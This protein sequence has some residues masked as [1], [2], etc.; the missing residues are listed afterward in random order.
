MSRLAHFEQISDENC[1]Q[2]DAYDHLTCHITQRRLDS[3]ELN[4]CVDEYWNKCEEH[5]YVALSDLRVL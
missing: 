1:G 4:D 3:F 2:G 5:V